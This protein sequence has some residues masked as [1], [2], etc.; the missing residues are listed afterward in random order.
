[1]FLGYVEESLVDTMTQMII[2]SCEK[3]LSRFT[4]DDG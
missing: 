1:M 2:Y 3:I 4:S